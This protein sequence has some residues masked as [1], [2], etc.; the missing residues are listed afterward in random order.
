[1]STIPD[2]RT[3]TDASQPGTRRPPRKKRAQRA[4]FDYG[5]RYV[6]KRQPDGRYDWT[7]VPLTLED[8]LHPREGDVHVLSDLHSDDRTY[9]RTVLKA[10]YVR[11]RSVAIFTD[12]GIYW[13]IPGLKHHSPDLAVI[14]GIKRRK[15][16]RTFRVKT[17]KVRPSL[18]IEVT[19]PKTRTTD[20][21]TKVQEYA[22]ARV[23]HY[24][25]VDVE[26]EGEEEGERRRITLIGYELKGKSY[27]RA[28]PNALGQVWLAPVN[29]WLGVRVDPETGGDRV[30]LIDP[31]TNEAIGDYT[32]VNLARIQATERAEAEARARVEAEARAIAAEAR[33]RELEAEMKRRKPRK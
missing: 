26:G 33:I 24:V 10:R 11:D 2:R 4:S 19:S 30:A 20:V 7:Q 25:I 1:M 22:L 23:P 12:L 18:I 15:S 21:E 32:A 27:K 9:L 5:Y 13:D 17:E 29:L 16:W 31:A 28:R 3:T 6:R 8:V 14:L